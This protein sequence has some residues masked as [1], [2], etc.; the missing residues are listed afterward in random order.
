MTLMAVML[1]VWIIAIVPDF[2]GR[3]RRI[4]RL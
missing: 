3:L 1:V 2:P 4:A